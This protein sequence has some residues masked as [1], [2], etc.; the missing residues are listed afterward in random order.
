MKKIL[1]IFMLIMSL[2][3]A[4]AITE[5]H[6]LPL[7]G[8]GG[9]GGGQYSGVRIEVST[10]ISL[11]NITKST[12]ASAN[13]LYIY[14]DFGALIISKSFSNN[15]AAFSE[16]E[17][18]LIGGNAYRLV[19]TSTGGWSHACLSSN[20]TLPITGQYIS[21]TN[22]IFP[23]QST[24]Q[25]WVYFCNIESISFSTEQTPSPPNL[26]YIG[27][28]TVYEN[29]TLTIQLEATD[30][31]V[32]D[33]LIFLTNAQTVLPSTSFLN[34]T[35]GEFSWKTNFNEQGFYNVN[36]YVTDGIFMDYET[37]T[38]QVIDVNF[39]T[40]TFDD[41][42]TIGNTIS[43]KLYDPQ[44]ANKPYLLSAS[45]GSFPGIPLADG[46]TIPLNNDWLFN[47]VLYTPSLFGFSR[48]IGILDSQG[49]G[50]VTWTIPNIAFFQNTNVH[51]SFITIDQNTTGLRSIT[52]ISPSVKVTVQ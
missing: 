23:D 20:P 11:T 21:W 8:Q 34:S 36:F 17:I 6:G 28:Q 29:Q 16:G 49:N 12:S 15:V 48:S 4:Y 45:F 14:D 2:H 25:S 31:N 41:N 3:T 37:V 40:I 52:S 44:S 38:I 32:N 10:N 1:F 50:Q 27:P 30:L 13:D 51:F 43:L 46:R 35:S 24:L 47:A 39:A 5:S 18:N 9:V 42:A 26:T 33:T 19:T 22:G 7:N